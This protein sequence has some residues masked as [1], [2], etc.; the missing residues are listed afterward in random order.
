M[1]LKNFFIFCFCFF[2]CGFVCA[3]SVLVFNE[4][5]YHPITNEA[6]MEWVELHNQMAVNLDVSGWKFKGGVDY[7]FPEGT[8]I[9][10]GE[11]VVIAS[12]PKILE[13]ATGIP[14]IYGPFSGKLSNNGETLEL[15][16][17]TD[18][19]M[20][21]VSYD[22]E[23]DWSIS[24]DG[25]GVSLAKIDPQSASKPFMNW[26]SSYLI[27]GTPGLQNFSILP[28]SEPKIS[29]NEVSAAGNEFWLELINYDDKSINLSNY[30]IRCSGAFFDFNLPEIEI[31]SGEFVI[32]SNMFGT[33]SPQSGDK[34]FLYSEN[35]K[36]VL[37]GTKVSP[38]LKGKNPDGE[39]SWMFPSISTPNES[40]YFLINNEIVINEIMYNHR[41]IRA[42]PG[43]YFST[44]NLLIDSEWKY[45]QSGTDFGTS[46]REKSFDDSV[47]SQGNSLFY[48]EDDPLPAQKNTLL[49]LGQST[50]YFR[51]TFVF[52][53]N[54]ENVDL[55][56]H[57][58]I[59]DGAVFY[60]NGEEVLR[61][62]MPDGE[63]THG[64]FATAAIGNAT[65]SG[66]FDISPNNLINGT[67]VMAVEVHQRALNSSDIVFG[68]ALYSQKTISNPVPYSESN[69]SWVELYNRGIN[70]INISGWKFTKGISYVFPE[71]TFIAAGEYIVVAKDTDLLSELHPSIRIFGN[72]SGKLSQS[73]ERIRLV[74]NFGN[75]ANEL[76]YF[77][78]KPWP[79]YTDGGGSSIEL[80]DPNSNNSFPKSWAAS[81][82][83][84]KSS[85][86]NYVYRGVAVP[87]SLGDD[88]QWQE[89]VIG[90]L[91]AGEVLLDDISVVHDPDGAAVE[92]LPNGTFN[93]GPANWRI[94]GTHRHSE[95]IMETE[96]PGNYVLKLVATDPTEHMHNH[97]ETTLKSAVINGQTYEI[98]FRAKWIAGSEQLNL[99]LYF[100]RLG[101]TILLDVPKKNGTPGAQNS[102][103]ETNIGPVYKFLKHFPAVPKAGENV[104]IS[105]SAEDNDGVS[106]LICWYSVNGDAWISTVMDFDENKKYSATIPGQSF[107]SIV[108]FY[109]EGYDDFG[110][111]STFPAGGENARALYEIDDGEAA[112]NGRHNIRIIMTEE[113]ENFMHTYI[114]L[115]SNDRINSTV[116]YNETDIF[117]N[118]G[119]RLKS[120]ERGRPVTAR[121]GFNIGFNKDKLF[122]GVHKTVAI[123]RS[124]GTGYGQREIL[125]NHVMNKVGHIPNEY[126]DL[127]KVIA[128][129]NEHTGSAELQLSRFGS[130]FLDNQFKNGG[131]GGVF[132]YDLI[133]YPLTTDEDGNKK[134]NPDGSVATWIRDLGD[135]KEDYRWI[136]LIKNNRFKDDYSRLMDCAKLFSL[137]GSTFNN[138]IE[139]IIDVDQWLRSFAVGNAD[140]GVDHY[141]C[142]SPHNAQFYVRPEDNRVLLFPHDMDYVFPNYDQQPLL[143][144]TPSFQKLILVPKY[145]RRYYGYLHDVLETAYNQSY[146]DY[147]TEHYGSLLPNQNFET[148]LTYI[149]NRHNYLTGLLNA[150]IGLEIP[151]EITTPNSTV[152]TPFKTV[153]G[154]AWINVDKITIN[155]KKLL[156]D[157]SAMNNWETEVPL[158]PGTN[159][160]VFVAHDFQNNIIASDEVTIVS[161]AIDPISEIVINEFLAKNDTQGSDEFG[162]FDDWLEL[163]NY[164]NVAA[165]VGGMFLSDDVLL[166]TKWTV[167]TTNILPKNFLVLW[168]DNET[169]Q[170]PYHTSFKLS[171]AGETISLYN[172]ETVLVHRITFGEQ[173]TD[174]S[175]GLFPDGNTSSNSFLYP[176]IGTNNILPEPSICLP[177]FNFGFWIYYLRKLFYPFRVTPN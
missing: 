16:N 18:R 93:L 114:K 12:L 11:Y 46:W 145:L 149:N 168:A 171:G 68:M 148:H 143:P 173:F 25:S 157:W 155:D 129:K 112:V 75:T 14:N 13:T 45:E 101:K 108:H 128:P 71:N 38:Q 94:I 48:V 137:S 54:F 64:T 135:S 177:F 79:D 88:D 83:S 39:G 47:W 34:L 110:V 107:P 152:E 159:N 124:E 109:I 87:S 35:E 51:T 116:I 98:S 164:G 156:V 59:D 119:V 146:M 130:E 158:V 21:S 58:I 65:Y 43:V 121:I 95:A 165:D 9:E 142:T 167:P 53:G 36:Y 20:D 174:I 29:F 8:I 166:P 118:V 132:E 141:I 41:D 74:D 40:N 162:E 102:V 60:L 32:F 169:N 84:L 117:Y 175:L 81:D 30:I 50:Y 82:E 115:M 86:Q 153:D 23:D 89:L 3:D 19:V 123:D 24:P 4:I 170:G 55:K 120:S 96:N 122:R 1:R 63:I 80:R 31:S 106:D 6:A 133:Y 22:D 67:N 100:N 154:N 76:R 28:N 160:L 131:D 78:G 125:I 61:L 5:M 176:T 44:T 92:L 15:V 134:P 72:F 17:N 126:N 7:T 139:N 127:I 136:F 27:G 151:F 105:V 42:T 26:R 2:G 52:T 144:N 161:L 69:E 103:Y 99:R 33:Y 172:P 70:K 163:Y 49:T 147:W 57:P 138:Q 104:T 91:D 111:R 62:G 77:D 113:D 140:G 150:Q 97:A 37:D 56:I 73:G 90:L 10:A 66:P 85:W